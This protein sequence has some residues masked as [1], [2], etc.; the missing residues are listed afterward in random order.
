MEKNASRVFFRYII[1][2]R[3][4]AVFCVPW[5]S[6]LWSIFLPCGEAPEGFFLY[7]DLSGFP[8]GACY[9]LIG[10]EL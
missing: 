4:N 7:G 6:L 3:G 1:V 5:G 2:F 8:F 10:Q 9:L